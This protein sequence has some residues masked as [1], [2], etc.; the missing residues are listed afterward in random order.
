MSSISVSE[1][2][3]YLNV[4][5]EFVLRLVDEGQLQYFASREGDELCYESVV[6]YKVEAKV[7]A[8]EAFAELIRETEAAD[9]Y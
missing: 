5:E 8:D 7:A 6:K 9:L 1:A 2:A 3:V 4:S